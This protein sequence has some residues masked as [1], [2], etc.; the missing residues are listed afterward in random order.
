MPSG[1]AAIETTDL[2]KSFGEEVALDGLSLAIDP[3]TV[4]GFLGPNGA[5][6]TTTMRILTGLSR[7]DGGSARV[8]GVAVG[9]ADRA[10]LADRVGYLPRRR[11]CTRSS[12]PAS[13]WSTPPTSATSPARRRTPGSRSTSPRST[14]SRT[15]TGGS[16]RTRRGCARRPPSSRPCCTS[17]TCCSSTSPRRG[18]TPR[19]PAPAR[20]D[21]RVR[22]RR[23]HG[24]PVDPH[25]PRGR[26][27]RRRGGVLFDGRLVAEGS[28]MRSARGPGPATPGRSR[29]PSSRSPAVAT[30]SARTETEAKRLHATATRPPTGSDDGPRRPPPRP[31]D[32][33]RRVRPQ[34]QA[35]RPRQPTPRRDRDPRCSCSGE[36][37]V[38]T[39]GRVR[40]R[41]DGCGRRRRPVPR[42]RGHPRPGGPPARGRLP[43]PRTDRPD[44]RRG[45]RPHGRPRPRGGGRPAGRRDRPPRPVVRPADR[46]GRDR[47]RARRR[48]AARPRDRGRGRPPDGVCRRRLGVR[49]RAGAVAAVPRRPPSAGW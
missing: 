39:P 32:R 49:R 23:R 6:K 44:R 30:T 25:P 18:W 1:E 48:R 20:V 36:P 45:V 14:W 21:R 35:V 19:R 42:R 33:S 15:R 43:D 31:A 41:P 16:R 47:V 28:P 22:R 13:S 27:R 26:G 3:G 5:G 17:P 10:S 34:R 24:V 12:A 9:V 29:T 4:Y 8:A 46:G 2:R 38:Q 11:R 7:P 37:A 40:V